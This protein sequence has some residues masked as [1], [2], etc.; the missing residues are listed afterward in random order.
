MVARQYFNMLKLEGGKKLIVSSYTFVST[1]K[2]DFLE[3][4]T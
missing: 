4:S 3:G 1:R 2:R